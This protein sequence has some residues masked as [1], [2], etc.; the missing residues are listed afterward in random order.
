[1]YPHLFNEEELR[2]CEM[3]LLK[4]NKNTTKKEDRENWV[5]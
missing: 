1:M 5:R 2:L 4:C 3:L